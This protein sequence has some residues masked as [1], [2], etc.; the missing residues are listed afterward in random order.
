[1][2]W[3]DPLL[4]PFLTVS[5]VGFVLGLTIH[6]LAWLRG[7][8]P[9][10]ALVWVL[11]GGLFALAI[12]STFISHQLAR[13]A[14]FRNYSKVVLRGSPPWLRRLTVL[15]GVYW[16]LAF[17]IFAV[18]VGDRKP[19]PGFMSPESIWLFSALW[20]VFYLNEAAI[21]HSAWK[22]AEVDAARRCSNG[23]QLPPE[24]NYCPESG[25]PIR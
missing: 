15:S 8:L 20:V 17:V 9:P 5:W 10:E 7:P 22:L 11:H 16:V 4:V 1:M 2:R 12:P 6:L 14:G 24:A 23:H 21:F 3:S 19:G 13:G 25:A 18:R